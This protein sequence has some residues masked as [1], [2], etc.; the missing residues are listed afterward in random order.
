MENESCPLDGEFEQ[1][2]C[3]MYGTLKSAGCLSECA[4]R[5]DCTS[6]R[7]DK[8]RFLGSQT[9]QGAGAAC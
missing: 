4:Y 7:D 9:S 1:A 6:L 2:S 3:S 5:E 8:K